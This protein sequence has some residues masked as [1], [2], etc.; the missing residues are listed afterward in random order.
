MKVVVA[1]AVLAGAVV[2]TP[3]PVEPGDDHGGGGGKSG[4]GGR[5]D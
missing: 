3:A 4:S 5:D 1:L 2:A